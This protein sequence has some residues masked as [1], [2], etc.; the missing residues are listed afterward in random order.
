M[1][2]DYIR[3]MPIV[4][5]TYGPEV[6]HERLL[7]LAQV[8]PDAVSRAV[9]CPEEPYDHALEPGDVD[10]RFRPKGPYDTGGLDVVVEVRSKWVPSRAETRQARCDQLR[11]AIVEATVSPSVGVYLCL[12][13]AAWSQ[14]DEAAHGTQ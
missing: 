4:E 12:P 10:L 1:L 14:G 7:R 11:D 2:L 9:D 5:V 13:V 3:G 6:A 8:L